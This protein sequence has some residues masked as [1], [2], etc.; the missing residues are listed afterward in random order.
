MTDWIIPWQSCQ[1]KNCHFSWTGFSII[2]YHSLSNGIIL[3]GTQWTIKVYREGSSKNERPSEIIE[4]FDDLWS[5][6]AYTYPRE[7][8]P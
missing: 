4:K 2:S 8:W 7:L 1:C 6:N 3:T 5:W